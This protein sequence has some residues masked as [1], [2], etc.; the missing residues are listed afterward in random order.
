MGLCLGGGSLCLGGRVLSV[1]DGRSGVGCGL[2]IHD[3]T[4]STPDDRDGLYDGRN[5]GLGDFFNGLRNLFEREP[6][7][8][9]TDRR[10]H[11]GL[12]SV[13]LLA[14]PAGNDLQTVD[15]IALAAPCAVQF[16]TLGGVG[17]VI[18]LPLGGSGDVA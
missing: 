15:G 2:G 11:G 4:G 9:I 16:A 17:Q 8:V 13:G 5:E 7:Q 3:G 6:G 14:S 1:T 12:D 18:R 10:S